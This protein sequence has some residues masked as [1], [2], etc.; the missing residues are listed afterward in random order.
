MINNS[1]FVSYSY[2]QKTHPVKTGWASISFENKAYFI[3]GVA[4]VLGALGS[5]LQHL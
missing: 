4:G 2:K 3:A 5:F 1:E